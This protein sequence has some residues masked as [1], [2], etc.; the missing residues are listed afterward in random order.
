MKKR[1]KAARVGLSLLAL[2]GCI[3][4]MQSPSY[5]KAVDRSELVI[6]GLEHHIQYGDMPYVFLRVK[7]SKVV[8]SAAIKEN[9]TEKPQD[10]VEF[11]DT[12]EPTE[13]PQ[14]N[15]EFYDTPEPTEKPK[16]ELVCTAT[17][18]STAVSTPCATSMPAPTVVPTRKPLPTYAPIISPKPTNNPSKDDEVSM[19]I[20]YVLNGGKN[21]RK[22]PVR[23]KK[24]HTKRLYGAKRKGYYF[25]G[26]YLD[27]KYHKKVTSITGKQNKNIKVYAKWKKVSVKKTVILSVKSI[28]K[29]R[30][31]VKVQKQ[32]A[33]KGYEYIYA[34][35]PSFTRKNIVRSKK[36]PKNL[37]RIR[38]KFCYIKV[39][40]YKIDSCENKIYGAYSRIVRCKCS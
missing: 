39:R 12:S 38:G 10:N 23:I 8:S 7:E 15:V 11:Y 35:T 29:G 37:C 40:S 26:W 32:T 5:V 4:Y 27:S 3:T 36:N 20:S 14:D 24:G 9:L 30:V 2:C 25:A 6:T 33:V 13:K 16:D 34:I 31:C 17:P 28:R 18:E 21:D 1:K 22:N 19:K